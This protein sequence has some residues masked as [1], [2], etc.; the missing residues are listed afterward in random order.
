MTATPTP[1]PVVLIHGWPV[2]ERHWRDLLPLLDKAGFEAVPIT[3]PGLGVVSEQSQSLRKA[4]LARW[5]SDELDR[6]GITR[7]A[8]IGHD[9][10]ATVAALLAAERGS[11]VTALIVE[12]E[13]LP[14]INVELFAPGVDCYPTWHGPFNRVPGL[15]EQLVPGREP[16]YYGAFLEQ[17]AGPAGLEAHTMRA[18]IDAYSAPGVLEAALGYYRSRSE[19]IRDARALATNPVLTPV[20]AI[21]GRFA[22]GA[23]VADGMRGVAA[24]VTRFIAEKSGHYPLEQEPELVGGAVVQF[25][26]QHNPP[27]AAP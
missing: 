4:D 8:L 11:A 13:I 19:D 17:S 15:A 2:T 5:L 9:W 18:Y 26:H 16:A 23:A 20:L 7:C 22:M 3:L 25:L 10:G 12:E 24:D 1:L 6:R 14:G 21:G 27:T